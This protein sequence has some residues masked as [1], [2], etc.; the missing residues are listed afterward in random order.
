MCIIDSID[1][2]QLDT[3]VPKLIHTG[4]SIHLTP[5]QQSEYARLKASL[6][7]NSSITSNLYDPMHIE[8]LT[9]EDDDDES[10]APVRRKHQK[11]FSTESK[12]YCCCV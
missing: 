10:N 5:S 11:I 8:V 12:G 1:L 2:P 7:T 3:V 4:A 9:N 6:S